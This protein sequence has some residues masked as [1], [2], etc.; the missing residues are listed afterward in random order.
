MRYGQLA[1]DDYG[2][3]GQQPPLVLL[4][5]LTFDRRHWTPV[6]EQPSIAASDRRVITFDLPGHGESP[7]RDSYRAA[8]VAEVLHDA[9]EEAGAEAPVVAGHSIGGA[10]ATTYASRYPVSGVVNIDQPLL[11]GGFADFL[12]Q[13]ESVLRS[14]GYLRVWE[15]L[16]AGMG[17][18]ELPEPARKLVC[19]RTTPRQ[20]LFLGYW[21]ELISESVGELDEARVRDLAAVRSAGVPYHYIAGNEVPA[22]YQS[23]LKAA[24]PDVEITVFAGAGHFAHL[25]RPAE[26]A[27]ILTG[28][29]VPS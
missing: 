26:V 3:G 21:D 9:I 1:A 8:E 2:S 12:K 20:D 19:T 5:G 25:T 13:S 24:L 11:A 16:L 27:G 14:D 17:V 28:I 6:L 23:W 7:D 18:G 4:H 29:A 22:A 15:T 10:L